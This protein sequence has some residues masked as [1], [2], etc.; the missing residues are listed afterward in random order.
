MTDFLEPP[1]IGVNRWRRYGHDRAY[2]SLG[3]A[4]L[5]HRDLRTGAVVSEN[6]AHRDTVEAA[7]AALWQE[8]RAAQYAPR[9]ASTATPP[10]DA[11]AA[12]TAERPPAPS[13]AASA[14][15]RDLAA[16]PPGAAV[17]ARAKQLRDAAPV[18]TRVAR[19]LGVKTDERAWR[20]GGD[21]EEA[22]ARRL[23]RLGP[24]WRVLH[25]IPVGERGSDIDHLVVG[26]G[27]VFTVNAKNHPDAAVWVRGDTVKV[28]GVSQPYVRNSRHEATRAGRLLTARAGFDVEV[29]GVVAIMG[30]ERGF[31]VVEQPRDTVVIVP[32]RRIA[33]HLAALPTVLGQPSIARIFD[34]ARH[35]ATWQPA[36]VTWSDSL[37]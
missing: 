19:V 36:T 3:E 21:A 32:R 10:A 1:V 29:R 35:L 4:K 31:T 8:C 22:V 37:L 25:S 16:N 12:A 20:I 28:N 33:D 7:T 9:H 6:P 26:P 2:V 5:G 11:A 30:M 14:P 23:A 24:G 27:G 17:H 34:V 18:R 13:D 15:D